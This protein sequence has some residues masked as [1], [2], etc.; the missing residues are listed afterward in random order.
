[1]DDACRSILLLVASYI[2]SANCSL[3]RT[4]NDRLVGFDEVVRV[5]TSEFVHVRL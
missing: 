3:A 4:A 1:M 5:D 2:L